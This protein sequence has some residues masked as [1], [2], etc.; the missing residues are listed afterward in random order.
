MKW[1]N[2][3]KSLSTFTSKNY[4]RLVPRA[5]TINL[6]Y[7]RNFCRIVINLSF[8]TATHYHPRLIF[9]GKADSTLMVGFSLACN[10]RLGQ[11]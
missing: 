8:A 10:I 1:S 11:T 5:C 7:G 2:L 9:A 6:F 3:Q 4:L